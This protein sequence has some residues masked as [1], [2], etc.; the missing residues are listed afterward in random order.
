MPTYE[1]SLF[2]DDGNTRTFKFCVESRSINGW[3][4][5]RLITLIDTVPP[6]VVEYNPAVHD[7]GSHYMSHLWTAR[8]IK[9]EDGV[10]TYILR[11]VFG[12]PDQHIVLTPVV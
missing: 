7:G 8:S 11:G 2:S 5:L 3:A 6:S 12:E 10:A 1:F 4:K 9:T